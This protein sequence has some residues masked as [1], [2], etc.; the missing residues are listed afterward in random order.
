[1]LETE[2]DR[3]AEVQALGSGAT[4]SAGGKCAA[5]I[6]E[7]EFG[8]AGDVEDRVPV[9]TVRSSDVACLALKNDGIVSVVNPFEKVSKDYRVRRLE[10]DG[11]GMTRVI[12]K[13][14]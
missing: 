6:L 4:I 13:A 3:L 11:T 5:C 10:P 8:L 2:A 7:N 14:A 1:M 9:C 12:L